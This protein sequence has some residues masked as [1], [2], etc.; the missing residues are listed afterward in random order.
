[1]VTITLPKRI[2]PGT[3]EQV[4]ALSSAEREIAKRALLAAGGGTGD[5]RIVLSRIKVEAERKK[6]EAER[7]RIAQEKQRR[8]AEERAAKGRRQ[9]R[10]A[11][12]KRKAAKAAK[13]TIAGQLEGL[14]PPTVGFQRAVEK[15][16]AGQTLSPAEKTAIRAR[17][18]LVTRKLAG[19]FSKDVS[20][21]QEIK[22]IEKFQTIE[23]QRLRGV[24]AQSRE[25]NF[26]VTLQPGER[27]AFKPGTLGALTE[28]QR[29][30]F[31]QEFLSAIGRGEF[32]TQE[33]RPQEV[34]AVPSGQRVPPGFALIDPSSGER[35]FG[36]FGETAGQIRTRIRREGTT[37]ERTALTIF[38]SITRADPLGLE[39]LGVAISSAQQRVAGAFGRRFPRFAREFPAVDVGA[40]RTRREEEAIAMAFTPSGATLVSTPRFLATSPIVQT[41]AFAGAGLVAGGIVAGVSETLTTIPTFAPA[42][43]RGLQV[44]AVVAPTAA[45]VSPAILGPAAEAFVVRP[46]RKQVRDIR[47]AG[48]GDEDVFAAVGGKAINIAAFATGFGVGVREGLPIKIRGVQVGGETRV[49]GVFFDPGLGGGKGVVPILTKSTIKQQVVTKAGETSF[50]LVQGRTQFGLAKG[51]SL[52]NPLEQSFTP[53]GNVETFLFRQSVKNLPLA[54]R[55]F[56]NSALAITSKT[57][58]ASSPVVKA[59]SFRQ[60]TSFQKLSP[61]G[62]KNLVRFIKQQQN[63]QVFGSSAQTVQ[64]KGGL[65]RQ[66]ADIDIQFFGSTAKS[67]AKEFG[68]LL[69]LTEGGANVQ[70]SQQNQVSIK[71]AG[72][73]Q[74]ILDVHGIDREIAP[75][76]VKN[77]FGF[78]SEPRTIRV[79]GIPTSRLSQEGVAKLASV[80]SLQPSGAIGPDPVKR[81]K[82]VADFFIIQRELAGTKVFGKAAI[83]KQLIL[84]KQ[85]AVSKFGPEIF[86][87]RGPLLGFSATETPSAVALL[88]PSAGV[89]ASLSAP[90]KVSFAAS[91]SPS[92]SKSIPRSISASVSASSVSASPSL[93]PSSASPSPSRSL[94]LSP[95]VSTSASVSP[96]ASSSPSPSV[97]PSG[98]PSVSPSLSPSLSPSPSPSVSV[99]RPFGFIP[100]VPFGRTRLFK[101]KT[102]GSSFISRQ[103]LLFQPSFTAIQLG[104]FGP[105]PLLP[106]GLGVSPFAIRAIP[107]VG[108]ER[109]RRGARRRPRRKAT[110]KKVTRKKT[111][112]RRKKR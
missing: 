3:L 106:G 77:P 64:L 94:S 78:S 42:V 79:S 88:T 90:S 100:F 98:S 43:A 20:P 35:V 73:F 91:P 86:L 84:F 46:T 31:G 21:I 25:T 47:E 9:I 95:S 39:T 18:I 92:F 32:P 15:R 74:K 103:P 59:Q 56:L 109:L 89:A 63:F 28:S 66:P 62:Q 30:T 83:D 41:A 85:A 2:Q 29:I 16:E 17:G 6:Q 26:G 81:L 53:S 67:K 33:I 70:I 58:F 19:T 87:E 52:G 45:F 27:L 108:R 97:S 60:V 107:I 10:A 54:E 68:K 7:K 57:Q 40:K 72:K 76:A 102:T 44:A 12:K 101:G 1:M 99:P 104:I 105:T 36:A 8:E 5:V 111:V 14:P 61:Q 65:G 71:V 48:G 4:L 49:Q 22:S 34:I 112:R 69:R 80:G 23:A 55:Q 93:S 110:R 82:D 75:S 13:Q 50:R 51:F 38:P 11:E 24:S 96:S 37:L